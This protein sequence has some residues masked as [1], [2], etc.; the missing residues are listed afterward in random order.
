MQ[1]CTHICV[2]VD[3]GKGLPKAIKL[4]LD[5][6]SHIQQLYYEQIPFNCKV[7]HE[8]GHFANHCPS[9]ANDENDPQEE[10]WETIKKKKSAPSAK[11]LPE[12]EP[13]AS[14]IVCPPHPPLP[15]PPFLLSPL[16]C[17]LL[18]PIPSQFYPMLHPWNPRI[19]P[20]FI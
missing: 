5:D 4:K 14:K 20:R 2:E 13:P 19:F 7:C 10:Q 9:L 15:H 17:P 8:Y 1:A 18:P 3:L 11:E 12:S 6:W 16:P